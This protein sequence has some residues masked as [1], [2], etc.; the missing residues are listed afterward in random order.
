MKQLLSLFLL[1]FSFSSSFAYV[2]QKIQ[3]EEQIERRVQHVLKNIDP[4]AQVLVKLELKN[5]RVDLAATNISLLNITDSKKERSLEFNDI[6]SITIKIISSKEELPTWIQPELQNLFQYKNSTLKIEL[7]KID[8][9]SLLEIENNSMKSFFETQSFDLQKKFLYLLGT[10]AFSFMAFF[11]FLSMRNKN[12]YSQLV[13]KL[14]EAISS[15]SKDHMPTLPPIV[16]VTPKQQS[17]S[18]GSSSSKN[19]H[20]LQIKQ[21]IALFSDC[22]WCMAD[23]YAAWLWTQL[24]SEQRLQLIEAW[25]KADL[26]SK[27]LTYIEPI[28]GNYHNHPTY[29]N[30]LKIE[31]TS[32]TDLAEW[33]KKNP[34]I[35]SLLPPLR[36]ETCPLTIQEQLSMMNTKPVIFSNVTLPKATSTDRKLVIKA[37]FSEISENDE[38]AIWEN[39]EL[40]PQ[41]LRGDIPTLVWL[42]QLEAQKREKILSKLD[43]QQVAQAWIGPQVVLDLIQSSIPEKKWELVESYIKKFT[44]S[45]RSQAFNYL[46]KESLTQEATAETDKDVLDESA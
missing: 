1:V 43:A 10:L 14:S 9:A 46:L 36:Q 44:P 24:S 12:H 26:Y 42:A 3:L 11:L 13:S 4:Y 41:E 35:W 27:Y 5:K 29:L 2:Q 15:S 37:N 30:P 19:L 38:L 45:R 32:Q 22:Y 33:L 16:D 34:G 21:V 7:E 40:V 18:V 23:N 39:P 8:P 28:S 6:Q 31:S 25:P 17:L 20:F